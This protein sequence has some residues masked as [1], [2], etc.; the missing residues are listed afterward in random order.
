[1]TGADQAKRSREDEVGK[2]YIQIK[3]GIIGHGEAFE[4]NSFNVELTGLAG[5]VIGENK[6]VRRR[7]L[8]EMEK[9]G[10]GAEHF[11]R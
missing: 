7:P 3:W 6:W 10:G 5:I 9:A 2:D 4:F 11:W 1:M 8:T